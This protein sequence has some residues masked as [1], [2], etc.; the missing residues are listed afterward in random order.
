[1]GLVHFLSTT[2][3]AL[4][5]RDSADRGQIKPNYIH[6]YSTYVCVSG[7]IVG[8]VIGQISKLKSFTCA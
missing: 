2:D 1:M 6:I 8:I 7:S 5:V 3:S 4:D